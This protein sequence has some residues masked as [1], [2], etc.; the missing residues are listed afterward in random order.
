MEK[1]VHYREVKPDR[2]KNFLAKGFK[3]RHFFPHTIYHIPKCGP[4]GYKLARRMC[5]ETDE[6]RLWEVILYADKEWIEEFRPDI[7][8]DKDLLWHEQHFGKAG[9]I[10]SANLIIREPDLYTN[11]HIS[12]LVQRISRFREYKTRIETKFKGWPHMLMNSV[13]NFAV[14]NG[15]R[16]VYCPTSELA[17]KHTDPKR[18]VQRALFHRV[19]DGSVEKYSGVSKEGGWWRIEVVPNMKKIVMADRKEEKGQCNH[20]RIAVCHDVE[21]G[22]GHFNV[23]QAFACRAEKY[24]EA[25]VAGILEIEAQASVRATYNVVGRHLPKIRERIEGSGHCIGFHSFSHDDSGNQL[26][27]CREVDYRIKGYRP[28]RSRIADGLDRGLCEHNFEWLASSAYSLQKKAP[29][30]ENRIVKIP[31]HLDDFSLFKGEMEYMEWEAHALSL[32]DRH[33]FVAVSLHD[34]YAHLW[35]PF[36]REF[37]RKLRDSATLTTL[38]EVAEVVT[39]E[40]AT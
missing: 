17:M 21:G 19:Y 15:L 27:R 23:D 30:M 7:F 26:S 25:N 1:V 5:A 6:N 22:L 28:P 16:T 20:R 12:D 35:L 34:C 10:A 36:Y 13:L 37:L 39:L 38:N 9:Q 2:L 18:T 33:R 4:D 32:L 40:S 31:I 11:V 14:E 8:F 3:K 24:F 29:V